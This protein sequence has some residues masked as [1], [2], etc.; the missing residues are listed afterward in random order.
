MRRAIQRHNALWRRYIPDL[1]PVQFGVLSAISSHPGSDQ[2]TI[3]E[4]A[5]VECSTMANLVGRMQGCGLL[6]RTP[7]LDDGRRLLL[8]LTEKGAALLDRTA[9]IARMITEECLTGLES[10]ERDQLRTLLEHICPPE[11]IAQNSVGT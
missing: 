8:N 2:R 5:A 10:D 11:H 9:P 6:S 7:D 1:T 3:G 4:C